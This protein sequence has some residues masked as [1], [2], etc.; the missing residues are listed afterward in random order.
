MTM[1][2]MKDWYKQTW[3]QC[4]A[5]FRLTTHQVQTPAK[6]KS[7]GPFGSASKK[8]KVTAKAAATKSK[9]TV[10][11]KS[12]SHKKIPKEKKN[13]KDSSSEEDE[14]DDERDP[15]DGMLPKS[16]NKLAP[17]SGHT[18]RRS[19][20][21]SGGTEFCDNCKRRF[22]PNANDTS[23]LCQACVTLGLGGAS[24]PR[25]TMKRKK[26]NAANVIEDSDDLLLSL[27]DLC[28]R[29]SHVISLFEMNCAGCLVHGV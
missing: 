11:S 22:I 9:H 24:K 29:V 8:V 5:G 18:K 12:K 21:F 27:K 13:P 23:M 26:K 3:H 14:L 25:Q 16:S 1:R 15:L 17:R 6:R 10:S 7:T 19:N 20:P 28:I 2:R 4:D